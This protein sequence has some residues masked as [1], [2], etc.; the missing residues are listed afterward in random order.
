MADGQKRIGVGDSVGGETLPWVL[1]NMV[2]GHLLQGNRRT[3]CNFEGNRQLKKILG[4]M[5]HRMTDGRGGDV[6]GGGR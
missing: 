3:K 5:E 1:G 2:K 6:C 4:N